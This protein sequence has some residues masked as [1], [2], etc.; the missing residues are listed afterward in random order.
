L[1]GVATSV[2]QALSRHTIHNN[3]GNNLIILIMVVIKFKNE[4]PARSEQGL[5][6]NKRY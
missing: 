4:N 6:I 3:A 2:L 1:V 5:G